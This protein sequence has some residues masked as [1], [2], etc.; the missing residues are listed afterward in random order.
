MQYIDLYGHESRHV[1][2]DRLNNWFV[3]MAVEESQVRQVAEALDDS[4]RHRDTSQLEEGESGHTGHQFQ[5]LDLLD[6]TQRLCQSNITFGC[7]RSEFDH[8]VRQLDAVVG[9][10]SHELV[11]VRYELIGHLIGSER[12]LSQ[13]S[14]LLQVF[15]QLFELVVVKAIEN[16]HKLTKTKLVNFEECGESLHIV[17]VKSYSDLRDIP[18]QRLVIVA[19]EQWHVAHENGELGDLRTRRVDLFEIFARNV[20]HFKTFDILSVFGEELFEQLELIFEVI[21]PKFGQRLDVSGDHTNH[22]FHVNELDIHDVDRLDIRTLLQHWLQTL[23]FH[24]FETRFDNSEEAVSSGQYIKTI[25]VI[26]VEF[27]LQFG[28]TLVDC[29]LKLTAHAL[30]VNLVL[31]RQI[32]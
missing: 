2:A 18:H 25:E 3:E 17:R 8:Q 7:V 24:Q 20:K 19:E 30:E 6:A 26:P 28:L 32:S 10:L 16:D 22:F 12:Q 21:Q 1:N 4:G 9:Q 11:Q 27:D 13:I 23:Y 15:S 14:Q 5:A 29:P 31:K